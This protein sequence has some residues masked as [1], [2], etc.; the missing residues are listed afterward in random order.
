M[1]GKIDVVVPRSKFKEWEEPVIPSV[2]ASI[3]TPKLA[4]IVERVFERS[5]TSLET[6]KDRALTEKLTQVLNDEENLET[7]SFSRKNL[8]DT[9]NNY[10]P[11]MLGF[12]N[13]EL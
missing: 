2:N 3:P 8:E 10:T 12:A 6:I 11:V 7:K 9:F 4:G 5:S 13:E 1:K